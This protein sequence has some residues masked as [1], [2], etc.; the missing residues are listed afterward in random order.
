MELEKTIKKLQKD[1]A[2]DK[3][4][5]DFIDGFIEGCIEKTLEVAENAL[6]MG[7]SDEKIQHLTKLDPEIIDMLKIRIKYN[8]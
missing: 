5:L 6:R 2:S 1:G 4:I 7:Y 3:Y 8:S